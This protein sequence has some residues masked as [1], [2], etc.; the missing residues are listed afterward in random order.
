MQLELFTPRQ[1]AEA[2]SPAEDFETYLAE[3]GWPYVA[4]AEAKKAIFA[5]NIAGFDFLIYSAEGPNLLALLRDPG[6]VSQADAAMMD[7]WETIFGTDF[8]A[9]FVFRRRGHW[10]AV[11]LR[12]WRRTEDGRLAVP[13]RDL[14]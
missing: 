4:V 7:E 14:I 8:A 11:A 13:L 9:A 10:L 3:K 6:T 2:G 5:H 12:D 1:W